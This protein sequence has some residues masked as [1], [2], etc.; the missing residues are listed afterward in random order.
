M[1]RLRR[2]DEPTIVSEFLHS[3]LRRASSLC[4]GLSTVLIVFIGEVHSLRT[5]A[6]GIL[7]NALPLT[8]NETQDLTT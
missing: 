6:I 8:N 2:E 4:S 7:D 5:R 3:F 1:M